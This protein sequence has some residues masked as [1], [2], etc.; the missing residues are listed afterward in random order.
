MFHSSLLLGCTFNLDG[1][2]IYRKRLLFCAQYTYN[3]F[4]YLLLNMLGEYLYDIISVSTYS[5]YLSTHDGNLQQ[6]IKNDNIS[7][8]VSLLKKQS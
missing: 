1:S 5:P 2:L 3:D 7:M 6:I 8:G 4:F